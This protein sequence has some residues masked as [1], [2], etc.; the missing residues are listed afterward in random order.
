MV[1]SSGTIPQIMPSRKRLP[2]WR[3]SAPSILIPSASPPWTLQDLGWM[4]ALI[5]ILFWSVVGLAIYGFGENGP[6]AGWAEGTQTGFLYLLQTI[7][8]LF[9]LY[10][11]TRV[12]YKSQ[13]QDFGLRK[14]PIRTLI[15]RVFQGL[16]LYYIAA[17]LLA[18]FERSTQV[19]I[20]GLGEQ[21]SHVPLFG[22]TMQGLWLGGMLLAVLAPLVEE[23]FFRGY[24]YQVFKKSVAVGWASVLS[25]GIFALF[26]FEFTVFVP[27]FLLG[28][29]LNWLFESTRSL[30][31]PIAFH[32]V[33]NALAFLVEIAVFKEWIEIPS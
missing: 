33:N 27:L 19:E 16:L 32:M 5:S 23:L 30:W 26:H 29:I 15:L 10:L 25:A 8:L 18:E 31:V 13:P 6:W 24:V 3:K 17:T 11:F 1:G 7:I 12:K 20:P 22:E 9:P 4:L 2:P 28:L 14:V 21:E